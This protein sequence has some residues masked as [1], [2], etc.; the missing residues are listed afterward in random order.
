MNINSVQ[1]FVGNPLYEPRSTRSHAKSSSIFQSTSFK[2]RFL[3]FI[4]LGLFRIGEVKPKP[5]PLRRF[6]IEA[7]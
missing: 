2:L 1:S 6:K 3:E 4:C 5:K 7:V